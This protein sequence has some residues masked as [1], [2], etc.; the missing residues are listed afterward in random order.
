[1]SHLCIKYK[2]NTESKGGY[3]TKYHKQTKNT[4][5]KDKIQLQNTAKQR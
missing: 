4:Q 3:N 2:K 1:M 5:G